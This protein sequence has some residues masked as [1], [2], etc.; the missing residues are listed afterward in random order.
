MAS[1]FRGANNAAG[2]IGHMHVL[3]SG[4]LCG[5]GKH[6]CFEAVASR[7]AIVKN[8]MRDIKAGKK[9]YLKKFAEPGKPIKSKALA[10]AVDKG[11][12]VVVDNITE[13]CETIGFVLSDITNLLNLDLIILG[14]GLIEAL[15]YFMIPVI[16][17]SFQKNVLKASAKGLKILPTKLGDDAAL[18]GGIPLAE[19]FL[20]IKV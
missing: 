10:A 12:K 5:C 2:E 18:Y 14:G 13:A 3:K 9:S 17:E 6:G 4:P 11:D 1:L 8:I 7:S 19:E 15:D 20:G 16:K